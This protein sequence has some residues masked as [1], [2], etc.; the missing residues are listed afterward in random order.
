MWRHLGL[1]PSN[2]Q[3][4]KPWKKF[5]W[6]TLSWNTATYNMEQGGVDRV[7]R[8][9]F[10]FWKW[11]NLIF[12]WSH[13]IIRTEWVGFLCGWY[14]KFKFII[15]FSRYSLHKVI[16]YLRVIL[17][18]W[19]HRGGYCYK[20]KKLTLF[21]PLRIFLPV[22]KLKH[23]SETLSRKMLSRGRKADRREITKRWC[24]DHRYIRIV[25]LR[26]AWAT[27][28]DSGQERPTSIAFLC[29]HIVKLPSKCDFYIHRQED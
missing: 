21:Y 24:P 10:Q 1:S 5:L 26:P 11:A 16:C 8:E 18:M 17:D 25:S 15:L 9:R 4:S 28:E 19:K 13:S 23:P 29:R 3:K 14:T 12:W 20:K 22:D 27:N 7:L 2:L 6:H